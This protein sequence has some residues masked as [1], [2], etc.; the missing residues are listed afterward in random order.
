M[1]YAH[2]KTL[3]A[4]LGFQDPDAREPLHD[5]GCEYIALERSTI[6]LQKL[7]HGDLPEIVNTNL[8]F[9]T[10]EG[11]NFNNEFIRNK[12]NLNITEV[13]LVASS[14]VEVPLTKGQ[15]QYKVTVGFLDVFSS[16]ERRAH[17]VGSLTK[18][19]S[20]EIRG[21]WT[22]KTTGK[23]TQKPDFRDPE[24]TPDQRTRSILEFEDAHQW[25]PAHCVMIDPVVTL[26]DE[27]VTKNAS[28]F[29]V[30]VKIQSIGIGDL[31][32]QMN[33]YREYLPSQTPVVV[34]VAFD[35]NDYF[36][37][38]LEREGIHLVRLGDNFT[39]WAA[40]QS[41]APVS[42]MTEI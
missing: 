3:L 14:R 19:N 29:S 35:T 38:A 25:T 41:S 5:L 12:M 30:E 11:I 28:S 13:E 34:A 40:K 15:D 24:I 6:S 42:R 10:S 39:T 16:W 9:E 23:V 8:Q 21:R 27:W 17:Q 2:D 4:R 26:V 33:L 37:S 32:R 20:K 36:R 18:P 1:T 22:N 7:I 31:L